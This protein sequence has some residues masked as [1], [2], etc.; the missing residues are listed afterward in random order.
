MIPGILM[1]AVIFI[2]MVA[3][4]QLRELMDKGPSS[5]V[6]NSPLPLNAVGSAIAGFIEM[7]R[8]CPLNSHCDQPKYPRRTRCQWT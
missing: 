8:Q 3:G 4:V 5:M 6:L 7:R 1:R 2:S